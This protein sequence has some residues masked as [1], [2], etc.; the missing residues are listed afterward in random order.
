MTRHP[1]SQIQYRRR[2]T[3]RGSAIV[4]FALISIQL[5]LVVLA[6]FEFGRMIIVYTTVANAAR[7]GVRYAIVH[8]STSTG[9]GANG[10]SGPAANPQ[11]VVDV[12]KDYAG[13]GLLNL[14]ALTVAVSYPDASNAPGKRVTVRVVYSYDPWT[15]LPLNTPLGTT[16]QGVI[17]F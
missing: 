2:S 17:T 4:E 3:G 15:L 7:V 11:N 1:G 9:S 10:P 12:V 14:N 5:L 6:A 13:A 16:T 8:G